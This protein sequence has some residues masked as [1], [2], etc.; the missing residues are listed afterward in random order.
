MPASLLCETMLRR[1]AGNS[2]GSARRTERIFQKFF[3][4]RTNFSSPRLKDWRGNSSDDDTTRDDFKKFTNARRPFIV[5]F[6]LRERHRISI[7]LE[8]QSARLPISIATLRQFARRSRYRTRARAR[9]VVSQVER[10]TR[11]P[12][13]IRGLPL[14]KSR[15]IVENGD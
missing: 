13:F 1:A 9:M 7:P 14:A 12:L 2:E 15:S 8:A 6:P 5:D 10:N 4:D 11:G 3:N